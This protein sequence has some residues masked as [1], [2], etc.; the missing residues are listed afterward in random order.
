MKYMISFLILASVLILNTSQSFAAWLI[1]HKPEFR[2]KVIDAETKKPIEGAV[3][4]VL[5]SKYTAGI[6]KRYISDKSKRDYYDKNGE[7]YF[8]YTTITPFWRQ[9][10]LFIIYAWLRQPYLFSIWNYSV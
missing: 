7:F 4:V 3:A 1:Y 9:H 6:T 2:G 5:Y 10:A 8:S